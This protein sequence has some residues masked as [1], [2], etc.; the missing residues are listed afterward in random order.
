MREPDRQNAQKDQAMK[1]TDYTHEEFPLRFGHHDGFPGPLIKRLICRVQYVNE[2]DYAITHISLETWD[3]EGRF[4]DVYEL[5]PSRG[6]LD[7]A[8]FEAVQEQL[9]NGPEA[10]Y[11][12]QQ[13]SEEMEMVASPEAWAD[14][15]LAEWNEVG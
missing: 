13:I 5:D 12:Q 14:K 6:M 10:L 7:K 15:M 11:L 3:N 9:T 8:V 4:G 2:A 1:F